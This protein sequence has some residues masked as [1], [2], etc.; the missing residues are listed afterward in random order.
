MEGCVTTE[1]NSWIQGQGIPQSRFP[2]ASSS[3]AR[4]A[5][6]HGTLLKKKGGGGGKNCEL[7]SAQTL[8]LNTPSLDGK[9][10]T[11]DPLHNQKETARITVE[12]G[13]DYVQQVKDNQKTLH[14]LLKKSFSKTTP[15]YGRPE[16]GHG[17]IE[18]RAIALLETSAMKSA[19]PY[20]RSIIA[21]WS[22]RTLKGETSEN[23]RYF[24]SNLEPK[25]RTKH[26]WHQLI[27][28]H[29]GGVEN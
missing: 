10:G 2:S 28:G 3:M 25:D 29:W 6:G 9:V 5:G 22:R 11:S 4:R 8:L 16:K 18:Q 14:P 26:H 20:A 1:I 13:G 17:R 19:F 24:I 12:K 23:V 7:K 27:R 15:A 21:V